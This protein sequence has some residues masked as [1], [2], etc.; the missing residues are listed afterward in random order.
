MSAFQW[1]FV[2]NV[3]LLGL[4]IGTL[5]NYMKKDKEL[6]WGQ[7]EY[8]KVVGEVTEEERKR[9]KRL[10]EEEKALKFL[11]DSLVEKRIELRI[12]KYNY[13]EEIK[14]KYNI[15]GD[16]QINTTTKEIKK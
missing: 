12:R 16:I 5:I 6:D 1:S 15:E 11:V 7:K 4:F 9:F 2:A 10:M 13:F 3:I 8:D 14:D